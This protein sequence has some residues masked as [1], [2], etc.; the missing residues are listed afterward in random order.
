MER[1]FRH[2]LAVAN[3][4]RVEARRDHVVIIAAGVAFYAVLALLPAM[5]IVVTLY[6]LFTNASDAER[7]IDGIL[8]MLP[9]DAAGIVATQLSSIASGSRA[10]LSVGFAM[11]IAAFLWTVS[12]ATR[13]MIGAVKIAYDQEDHRSPLE[14]R[15]VALAI[16]LLVIGGGVLVLAVIAVVPLVL[17]RFDPTDAIV[18]IA[19]IRWFVIGVGTVGV[20]SVLYRYAPPIRPDGWKD[21]L[22]G[23]LL[24]TIL[25]LVASVGFSIYV[26]SYGSYNATY[27]AL[28]GAVVLL[29]WFW[30]TSLSVIIGAEF[31]DAIV[32]RRPGNDDT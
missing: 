16:T 8:S 9:D 6:G 26:S 15:P 32:G 14:S 23:A 1:R 31:N 24:G 22:P 11:S 5:F 20:L 18:T 3:D 7:Q 4:V 25:W 28:G 27:G 21:V 29:L 30:I 13:A 19:N 12:N 10:G 2:W 17:Q